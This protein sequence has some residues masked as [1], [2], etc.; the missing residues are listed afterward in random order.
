M[1]SE[2]LLAHLPEGTE[3]DFLNEWF[4]SHDQVTHV[5]DPFLLPIREYL[6]RPAKHVRAQLVLASFKM[7]RR[8]ADPGSFEKSILE[9]L[10]SWVETLHAGSLIIDDIQDASMTRREGQALH[11]LIGTASSINTA[12][13][14]YF[15]P[16]DRFSRL[17]LPAEMELRLYRSYHQ[18]MSRAH[19]GQA[20]DLH[21]DMTKVT[22]ETARAVSAAAMSL[23]T[24]ELMRMSCEFGAIAASATEADQKIL[25]EFGRSFGLA[26]QMWNDL[27]EIIKIPA[28]ESPGSPLI[29]P[30]LIWQIASETLSE[31]AFQDFQSLMK[32]SGEWNPDFS[33]SSHPVVVTARS[34]AMESMKT[35]I[36][37]IR[38]HFDSSIALTP[39]VELAEKV[40]HG[41][42]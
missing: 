12:N 14:L 36:D 27:S 29:R 25:S 13:W 26:L 11:G 28:G 39:I 40:I 3:L 15:W 32:T 16:A 41:Y 8:G 24:G 33:I 20:L 5:L 38:N 21:Y 34:R 17:N 6:G 42:Q 31:P 22:R 10:A 37:S 35:C 2:C 1:I 19:L 9:S 23:K 4:S 7:V 18:M 30:S